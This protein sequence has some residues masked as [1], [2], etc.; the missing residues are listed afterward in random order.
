M[1]LRARSGSVSYSDDR[2]VLG[3][4]ASECNFT[5]YSLDSKPASKWKEDDIDNFRIKVIDVQDMFPTYIDLPEEAKSLVVPEWEN[6]NWLLSVDV[7]LLPNGNKVKTMIV[8]L[9]RIHMALSSGVNI[10][11]D[12]VDGFMDTLL[13]LLCFDDYPCSVY[14]QYKH[15]ARIKNARTRGVRVVTA[16]PDFSVLSEENKILL[17]VEDKISSASA[18]NN[19]MES[20]VLGELF[21]AFHNAAV[22]SNRII[23]YPV[24]LYAVRVVNTITLCPSTFYRTSATLEYIKETANEGKAVNNELIVDRY[25]KVEQDKLTVYDILNGKDRLRILQC[26]CYIRKDILC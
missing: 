9:R 24:I 22:M 4:G 5:D 20:Q 14:P 17:V 6:G 2:S 3:R 11:E 23:K 21:V 16:K 26:L 12:H 13:H 19:W 25:P 7:K 8:K 18:I 1:E 10:T 15:V